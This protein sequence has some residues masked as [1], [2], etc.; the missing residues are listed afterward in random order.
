MATRKT[1]GQTDASCNVV[2]LVWGSL[3][4]APIT[5]YLAKTSN[6]F[7]SPMLHVSGRCWLRSIGCWPYVYLWF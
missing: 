2:T 1:D 6:G 7:V 3:R 4:V 5:C